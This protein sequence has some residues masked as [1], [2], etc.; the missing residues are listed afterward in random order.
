M[1]KTLLAVCCLAVA[2][3]LTA[4]HTD[5][6]AAIETSGIGAVPAHPRLDNPR[7]KSIFAYTTT[8]NDVIT[9]GIK[10]VNNTDSAKTLAVYPVDSQA[11]SDGAF[12]CAQKVDP[13][14][15]V[16]SW[17]KLAQSQVTL[18]ANGTQVIPFTLTVPRNVKG[19]EHNGCIVVQDA[20]PATK[21]SGN[22][23][24]L[25]FRSALRVAVTIPG[26]INA[27]LSFVDVKSKDINKTTLGIS[28][29]LRNNGDISIDTNIDITLN[30]IFALD[31]PF[32]HTGGEF[33]A[34]P[35]KESRYNFELKK[36]FWGGWY[37]RDVQATYKK[38]LPSSQLSDNVTTIKAKSIIVFIM[39]KPLALA[40]EA[41]IVLII[42]LLLYGAYRLWRRVR[43]VPTE[44]YTV[45]E[46]DSI[47]S[48][49][50]HFTIK[51]QKLAKMNKIESPYTVHPG[52]V[53]KVPLLPRKPDVTDKDKDS[54][55]GDA[56]HEKKP[57]S[58]TD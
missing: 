52:H 9:D 41:V 45:E 31:Y 40:I 38:T 16:G 5:R 10:V 6:A 36:P 43:V 48:I 1:R 32:A 2:L 44:S 37:S 14:K 51:W 29:I 12:A 35:N 33:P 13:R 57:P 24:V 22:G 30:G 15:E 21:K 42:V 56:H 8:T 3:A 17:I 27:D 49:A 28:P 19:G 54:S 46:G 53:I 26:T 47:E 25:S 39:P 20:D 50:D 11:S 58:D 4:V 23:I 55:T 34:F 18:P 7:T